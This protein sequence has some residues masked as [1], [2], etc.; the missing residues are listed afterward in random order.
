MR[1]V[2]T[3]TKTKEEYDKAINSYDEAIRID[4][5]LA[6]PYRIR[7]AAYQNKREYDRARTFRAILRA[8]A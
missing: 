1:I 3:P 8:R 2:A 7:G 5:K 6:E 4:P